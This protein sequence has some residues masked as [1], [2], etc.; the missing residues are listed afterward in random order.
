MLGIVYMA[1][2]IL[3]GKKYIGQTV[4]TLS[5]RKHEHIKH[6]LIGRY[7]MPFHGSIRKY[8]KDLEGAAAAALSRSA[9]GGKSYRGYNCRYK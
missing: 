2:N 4:K 8:G 6:A 9:R 7:T 1:T 5:G 3:N